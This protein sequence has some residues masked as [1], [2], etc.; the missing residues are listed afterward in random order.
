MVPEHYI[1]QQTLVNS[2]RYFIPELKEME[3]KILGAEEKIINIEYELFI[4]IRNI[5]LTK[6]ERIQQTANAIAELDVLC[7]FAEIAEENNYIKPVV[8][9][10]EIIDIKDGRH[11]VVEKILGNEMFIPNDTYINTEDEQFLIITGLICW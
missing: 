10:N 4:Q 1:R 8:N 2:E 7:S 11:P 6:I 5:L 9:N 3:T